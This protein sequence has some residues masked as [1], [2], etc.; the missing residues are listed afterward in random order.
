MSGALLSHGLR[1]RLTRHLL[2]LVTGVDFFANVMFVFAASHILGGIGA[3]PRD[4]VAVQASYAV[5]SMLMI[6]QQQWLSRRFGYRRYLCAALAVYIAGSIGCGL[7]G[8]AHALVLARFVQGFGAGALFTSARILVNLMFPPAERGP[9]VKS[10]MLWIFGAS[11]AAPVVAATL[12]DGGGGSWVFYGVVPPAALA[13]WGAFALL[14]D[15]HPQAERHSWP[16]LPL[17]LFALGVAS[18]QWLLG[19]A[20]FEFFSEP[21]HLLA[22][23][24]L[25]ALA[26]G[27]F[28]L[29]QWHH[30]AP[31]LHLRALGD[32]MFLVG[33]G[34]YF[35]YYLLSN[36]MGYV[37]PV[38][39]E[40]ALGFSLE[41]AAFMNSASALVSVAAAVVYL[42]HGRKVSDRRLLMA[43][44]MA[45]LLFAGLWFA[46]LPAGVS[47]GWLWPGLGAKGLFGVLFILPVAALTFSRIGD[48]FGHGYAA[49]NL[50]RALAQSGATALAAVWLQ[51]EQ[52]GVHQDLLAYVAPDRPGV[53]EW[54]QGTQAALAAR[55][56]DPQQAHAAALS[57]LAGTV[58]QQSQLVACEQL[59]LAFALVASLAAAAVLLQKRFR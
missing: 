50:L 24:V 12:A 43:A 32:P 44:G 18:L 41:S 45:A 2:G 15:A 40:Q 8:D 1:K 38:Y 59:Y 52:L 47:E 28:F 17:A 7:A 42:R 13:L 58:D 20:R 22:A 26:L 3:G 36:A 9:A 49:K 33:L 55:G 54:L 56:L 10:F 21:V 31:L 16:L 34:F 29:H 19:S 14:P 48:H 46:R 23:L 35:A 11:A 4:L 27:A 37:F 25:G 57:L 39:A 51:G 53:T 30:H 5:G 6:V